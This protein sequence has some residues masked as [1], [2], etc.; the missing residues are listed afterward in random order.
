MVLR[1]DTIKPAYNQDLAIV[2]VVKWFY[3]S[4]VKTLISV[5]PAFLNPALFLPPFY[6]FH[7][8]FLSNF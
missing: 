1:Y 8:A 6:G 5:A 3:D 4:T 7:A 2:K